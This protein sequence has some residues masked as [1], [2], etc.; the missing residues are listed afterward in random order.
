MRVL[1]MTNLYPNPY[2]PQRGTFVRHNLRLLSERHP[3]QVISPIAWT[4]ERRVQGPRLPANRRVIH[5]GLV[6]DHPRY[7]YTPKVL[8]RWYGWFFLGAVR[9]TFRAAVGEF[10][11]DVV[12]T[13][14]AYPDGWAA[15]RL[16]RAAELPVVLG[17][18]G[19]DLR[20]I[21]DYP[22]RRRPTADALRRADGVGAVSQDL[23]DRA[24]ELGADRARTRVIYDGVDLGAFS[25][26]DRAGARAALGLAEGV[27]HVLCIANLVRV[28]GIDVLLDACRRLPDRLGAWQLH[29]IGEGQ[30]RT[31]LAQQAARTGLR[32][33]VRFHGSLPHSALPQW[34]R[35]ADLFV[36]ASRSEGIPNVLLEA[37]ACRVP[38][39]A[40]NVG[41]IPE[42]AHL[43]AG[44]LVPPEDPARFA[45]A[46][47]DL[48]ER[49]PPVPS[50]GPHDRRE[51]VRQLEDFL[52]AT[53]SRFRATAV[54]V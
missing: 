33:R 21:D 34:F 54:S 8:R 48:L 50:S 35:A 3:V 28:K 26:G 23:A 47:A 25:P 24:I 17:V 46:M 49:P 2:Q 15:V 38:F 36:L 42:M 41:G 29:V 18:L 1:A 16:A 11:P 7:W 51:A 12:Y 9:K 52:A 32:D 37:A 43:G 27:R 31:R 39:V 53:I 4:D 40:T 13:P 10:R 22:A 6:V 20:L 45:E 14:W 30:L 5:D 44:R 19:S